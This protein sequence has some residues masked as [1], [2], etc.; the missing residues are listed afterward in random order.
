[1]FEVLRV[2]KSI[3]MIIDFN[4]L[5]QCIKYIYFRRELNCTCDPDQ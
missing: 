2:P 1:M 3:D 5:Y 4:S